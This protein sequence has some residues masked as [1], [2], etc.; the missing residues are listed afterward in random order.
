[1]EDKYRKQC[2]DYAQGGIGVRKNVNL[3]GKVATAAS[4]KPSGQ[5]P[6]GQSQRMKR[7]KDNG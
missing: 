5:N 6:S 2:S 7:G 4:I 3:S 1:M